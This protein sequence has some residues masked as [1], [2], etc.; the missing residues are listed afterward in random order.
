MQP[1]QEPVPAADDVPPHPDRVTGPAGQREV[2][3]LEQRLV[4]VP[5]RG[6]RLHTDPAG[7]VQVHAL[8]V[9]HVDDD[10]AVVPGHEVLVTVA[11]AAHGNAQAGVVGSLDGLDRLAGVADDL[12][13]GGGGHPAP[14]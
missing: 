3:V 13:I 8:H 9:A 11:A 5:H 1:G 4:Y 14:A 7:R 2:V 6:A 10:A 12:D